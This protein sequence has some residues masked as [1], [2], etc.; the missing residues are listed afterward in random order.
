MACVS[1][2]YE[3]LRAGG[4]F[5][6]FCCKFSLCQLIA[7]QP[8]HLAERGMTTLVT[9]LTRRFRSPRLHARWSIF[10]ASPDGM[11]EREVGAVAGGNAA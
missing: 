8:E 1:F 7:C 4:Q 6:W 2:R 3:S 5:G 9:T 10:A 11:Q